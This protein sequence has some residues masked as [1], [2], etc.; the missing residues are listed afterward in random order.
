MNAH[1]VFLATI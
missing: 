1:T